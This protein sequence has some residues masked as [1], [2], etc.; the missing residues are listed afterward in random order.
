M[1]LGNELINPGNITPS[2]KIMVLLTV[3]E[4]ALNQQLYNPDVALQNCK[5]EAKMTTEVTRAIKSMDFAR[6]CA[7]VR[8]AKS[9]QPPNAEKREPKF[10]EAQKQEVS[11][12]SK[13]K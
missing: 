1:E 6:V 11:V 2:I 5:S 3:F 13:R 8:T 9:N 7:S 4:G 12:L 10:K